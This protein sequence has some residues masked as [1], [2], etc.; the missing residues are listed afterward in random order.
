MG[1]LAAERKL[2][3]QSWESFR[4]PVLESR[5]VLLLLLLPKYIEA[6]LG[7]CAAVLLLHDLCR[8]AAVILVHRCNPVIGEMKYS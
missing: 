7:W 2:V 4:N 6:E 3:V 1:Y 5:L 8:S